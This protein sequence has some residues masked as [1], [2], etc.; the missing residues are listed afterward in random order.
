MQA[1]ASGSS[2]PD[3]AEKLANAEPQALD[4]EPTFDCPLED[5][6]AA[7]TPVLSSDSPKQRL[8]KLLR[9]VYL[10]ILQRTP[11]KDLLPF[12][13]R[14]IPS[15][16]SCFN[17]A[18][19]MFVHTCCKISVCGSMIEQAQ[20]PGEFIGTLTILHLFYAIN[21]ALIRRL[22]CCHYAMLQ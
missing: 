20:S 8:S 9:Q 22:G 13:V 15:C 21:D 5:A 10:A 14:L 19:E 12:L 16:G 7:G 2:Q 4:S 17:L 1:T 18:M 6:A 3:S 11:G